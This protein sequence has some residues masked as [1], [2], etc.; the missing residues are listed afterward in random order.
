MKYK[1]QCTKDKVP[2]YFAKLRNK[3]EKKKKH[4]VFPF[5][6]STSTPDFTLEATVT[7]TP[8]RPIHLPTVHR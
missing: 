1:G 6:P 8:P 4:P 5:S 2:I 7:H 3:N